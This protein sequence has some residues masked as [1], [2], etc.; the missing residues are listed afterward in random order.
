M[1]LTSRAIGLFSQKWNMDEIHVGWDCDKLENLCNTNTFM[2]TVNISSMMLRTPTFFALGQP[3]HIKWAASA[4]QLPHSIFVVV[5]CLVLK[6]N[7]SVQLWTPSKCK[8]FF[9]V[10]SFW[11]QVFPN[12]LLWYREGTMYLISPACA[13]SS[14]VAVMT[15]SHVEHMMWI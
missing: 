3:I 6:C 1:P 12:Y 2:N 10:S 15:K 14:S 9:Y 8:H 7:S 5:F 13:C 4:P 11:I